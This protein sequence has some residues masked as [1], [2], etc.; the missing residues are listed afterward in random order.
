MKEVKSVGSGTR[1]DIPGAKGWRGRKDKNNKTSTEEQTAH[2]FFAPTE[3][4]VHEVFVR[5][6]F[7]V[8]ALAQKMSV[9]AAEV[10][11]ALMKMGNMVTIN[12]TLDQETAMIVVEELGHVAK[13]AT[14][15]SPEAFLAGILNCLR[16]EPR[17]SRVRP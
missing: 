12:Q 5:K 1:G 7:S 14:L 15:D 16:Q 17:L 4:I 8:G 6:P 10:I 3:P 9:K 13:Y 2:S 11:K